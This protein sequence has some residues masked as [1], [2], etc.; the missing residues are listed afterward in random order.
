MATNRVV[1]VTGA[2]GGIGSAICKSLSRDGYAI[3]AHYRSNYGKA[4]ALSDLI[5]QRGGLCFPVAADFSRADGI[6][7]VVTAVTDLLHRNPKYRLWTLVNNAARLL[8]PSFSAATPEQFDQYFA[9][10][11]KAPLFLSQRLTEKMATGG[12]VVNISSASA[13]F[14]SPGD[15]VYAMSKASL[16]SLTMNMAEAIAARGLRVNTV[17]P[18][19]TD[20]GH[21]A[22]RSHELRQYMSSFA[23]LGDVAAPERV[24]DAVSFLIS[25]RASRTTGAILDVSGGSALGA[26]GSRAA[27]IGT[28]LGDHES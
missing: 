23:V 22:F 6:D 25:D 8:G 10:N 18:G 4:K 13:H 17:V 3:I 19:F 15:I 2:T 28:L 24:A 27:S 16:E 20:N 14:S 7:R 12:S 26:R 9:I 11:V 1:V 5:E 21:E